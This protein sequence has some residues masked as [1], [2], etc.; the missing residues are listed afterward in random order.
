MFMHKG[1]SNRGVKVH[2]SDI[3]SLLCFEPFSDMLGFL[4]RKH[5]YNEDEKSIA[6]LNTIDSIS[7]CDTLDKLKHYIDILLLS[8]DF[9]S[10][11]RK[12]IPNQ[13][14][15]HFTHKY[16]LIVFQRKYITR[17]RKQFRTLSKTH[18]ELLLKFHE[19]TCRTLKSKHRKYNVAMQRYIT[20]HK[21]E[22][23][24]KLDDVVTLANAL[25]IWGSHVK[26]L[27]TIARMLSYLDSSNNLISY[28]GAAH[29][30]TYSH[31]FVK[32]MKAKLL[33]K[34]RNY[35]T[36]NLFNHTITWAKNKDFRC[37][38]L[39]ITIVKEVFDAK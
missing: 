36:M 7:W 1:Q 2:Y 13:Y 31:F 37:V 38:T 8:D 4:I 20:N 15:K 12:L 35:K 6:F 34:V 27:Y 21:K 11:V 19:D 16:D 25:L 17:I 33:H 23:K 39:P 22:T 24:Q 18:Q 14:A 5:N 3:R 32:Y 28:D 9:I 30:K 26:D 10:D 29:S